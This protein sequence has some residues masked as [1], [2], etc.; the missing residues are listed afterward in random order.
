MKKKNA[1]TNLFLYYS[2][3]VSSSLLQQKKTT[4]R[5]KHISTNNPVRNLMVLP[6]DHINIR[7]AEIHEIDK[8]CFLCSFT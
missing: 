4:K 8:N 3:K 5:Q 7:F 1:T 6:Q 2:L